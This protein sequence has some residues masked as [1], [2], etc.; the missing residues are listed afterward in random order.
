MNDNNQAPL[1]PRPPI[2]PVAGMDTSVM[3]TK[4]WLICLLVMLVPCVNIVMAFVW[5]FS[6]N[7]NLNRRNFFRAY[8]IYLAI[9]IVIVIIMYAA[10]FGAIIAAMGGMGGW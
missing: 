8:L 1:P 7:G 10:M 4:D 2:L 3:Q 9:A 5:A 6:N